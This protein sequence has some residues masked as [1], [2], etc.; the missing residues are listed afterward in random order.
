[1]SNKPVENFYVG[2]LVDGAAKV[3]REYQEKFDASIMADPLATQLVALAK[4]LGGI[5]GLE[6]E[7]LA[8]V[9]GEVVK[10]WRKME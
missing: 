1:M 7:A 4:A 10:T 8:H 5:Y 6:G 3:R 2:G 9:L